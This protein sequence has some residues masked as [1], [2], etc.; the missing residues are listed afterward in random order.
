MISI[1]FRCI[2][3][4]SFRAPEGDNFTNYSD[5][6]C[7]FNSPSRM[8]MVL[9]LVMP[10]S[11]TETGQQPSCNC[12]LNSSSSTRSSWLETALALAANG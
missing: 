2:S 1:G 7:A 3:L 9:P 4:S 6:S 12:Q 8:N 11:K 5:L 10:K